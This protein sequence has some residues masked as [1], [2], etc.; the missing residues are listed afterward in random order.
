M[1]EFG[2]RTP[3]F[4]QAQA[5][6]DCVVH[7]GGPV[8]GEFQA[9]CHELDDGTDR[10]RADAV[11]GS[12]RTLHLQLPVDTRRRQTVGDVDDF[13]H[14]AQ[15]IGH[16]ASNLGQMR[17]VGS[18]Q[19]DLDRLAGR[20][21]ALGHLH[22]DL[23]AR[24]AGHVGAEI[25]EDFAGGLAFA[26]VDELI[27]DHAHH[28]G[29]HVIAAAR[30][31]SD[32]RVDTLDTGPAEDTFL[33]HPHCRILLIEREVSARM[34]IEK[35]IFRFDTGEEFDARTVFAVSDRHRDQK[36]DGEKQHDE[37][38]AHS[39]ADHPH[40]G[41]VTGVLILRRRLGEHGTQR[42]RENQRVE[43][44]G[45]QRRNQRD[46]HVF[47]E[48]ADNAGP[49]QKRREG[50]NTRERCRN[51]RSRHALGGQREGLAPVHALGHSP[52]CELGDDDRVID[53]HAD[54]EDQAEQHDDIDREPGQRERENA[55]QERGGDRKA[56][57]QRSAARQRVEDDDEDENDGCENGVLQ[58]AEKLPDRGRLV[59]A[60]GDLGAFRQQVLIRLG[61]LFY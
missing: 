3:I 16:P 50:G 30:Y 21:T 43:K 34:Y 40:I 35:P 38:M 47:H 27:L 37:G 1:I 13:G 46:R 58:V 2:Q 54:G 59:L 29:R 10:C 22:L 5:D 41:A 57:Q 17:R 15:F 49:E 36:A 12:R 48:F 60:V 6:I 52:F 53:E 56:D 33:G 39:L 31:A 20:R 61:R 55:H 42:R 23:D 19:F 28:I 14:L 25:L 24:E 26:P 8:I 45:R 9:G 44:R 4:R 51:H 32:A 18:R 7:P 11:A